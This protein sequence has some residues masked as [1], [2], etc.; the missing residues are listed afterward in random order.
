MI[1]VRPVTGCAWV[2]A[3]HLCSHKM[4]D[5]TARTRR[6]EWITAGAID[7]LVEDAFSA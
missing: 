2:D 1:L 7:R 3:Q 5:T 6:D 4:S